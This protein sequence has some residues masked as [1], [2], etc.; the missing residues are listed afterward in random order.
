MEELILKFDIDFEDGELFMAEECSS[1]C[2]YRVKTKKELLEYILEY[3]MNYVDANHEFD[4]AITK[5]NA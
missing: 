5:R 2:T 3:V 1:G 4:F